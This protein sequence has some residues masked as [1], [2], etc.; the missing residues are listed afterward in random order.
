MSITIDHYVCLSNR[1]RDALVVDLANDF[2]PP[3]PEYVLRATGVVVRIFF[4]RR[5]D[6]V[7]EAY[8]PGAGISLHY[9]AKRTDQVVGATSPI[10]F[11]SAAFTRDAT[12]PDVVFWSATLDL[13]TTEFAA[14]FSSTT[15]IN[16]T[17]TIE[18]EEAG[19]ETPAAIFDA[20]GIHDVLRDTDTPPSAALPPY[21]LSPTDGTVLA[22]GLVSGVLSW[23]RLTTAQ[24]W[25]RFIANASLT[26]PFAR[27]TGVP[28]GRFEIATVIEL[29]EFRST[30]T[31]PLPGITQL[32]LGPDGTY[33]SGDGKSVWNDGGRW[34]IDAGNGEDF[35]STTLGHPSPVGLVYE[36]G[37]DHPDYQAPGQVVEGQV[38]AAV[39]LNGDT[40]PATT[41]R[42]GLV[43][44]AT[45]TET[46]TGTDTAR[47]VTPASLTSRTATETRRGIVELATPAEATAGTDTERA[48]TPAGGL[49]ALRGYV[50]PIAASRQPLL[51]WALSDP[52]T[53]LRRIWWNMGTTGNVTGSPLTMAGFLYQ[54][55]A[56]D[57]VNNA[58]LW[59]FSNTAASVGA[60]TGNQI[61]GLWH[62]NNGTLQL[63][64]GSGESNRAAWA[65]NGWRA[66]HAGKTVR[67]DVVSAADT[68]TL[69][70]V[71]QD[72]VLLT[73]W[74]LVVMAGTPP[75]WQ[76]P[77]SGGAW[78]IQGAGLP[79]AAFRPARPINRALTQAEVLQMIQLGG[80]LPRDR[81]GGC[82][83]P[84]ADPTLSSD[85]S[86][87]WQD[88]SNVYAVGGGQIVGT[89]VAQ[90]NAVYAQVA[91]GNRPMLA[92]QTV[93]YSIT[94]SA[95][96]GTFALQQGGN[97]NPAIAQ[98]SAPGTYSGT[99]TAVSSDSA[100]AAFGLKLMSVGPGSI[101]VTALTLVYEG[102]VFQDEVTR[103]AQV[104]DHGPNRTRGVMTNGVRPLCDRDAV[105]IRG[106]IAA[107]GNILGLGASDPLVYEPVLIKRIRIRP[108]ASASTTTTWRQNTS[109]GATIGTLTTSTLNQ[110][111][112]LPFT[113]GTAFDLNSGDKL[114]ITTT[115]ALDF[116]IDWSRR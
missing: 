102:A 48:L 39:V 43:E 52:A 74:T 16:L 45:D 64:I 26:F 5:V 81:A 98:F 56:V 60:D 88:A 28:T 108:T 103:T 106:S 38:V 59:Q 17:A 32:T 109:V 12:D 18:L 62:A 82:V 107:T 51:E 58:A 54:V 95:I 2:A 90:F 14:A 21:P 99:Y 111:V 31:T 85:S 25:A 15:P 44:L 40:A 50:D 63:R 23:V 76:S 113:A 110:W 19:T 33:T 24:L 79:A 20:L 53:S 34:I 13:N 97:I 22:G 86:A 30:G 83:S 84:L 61:T 42:L 115:A 105:P 29:D 104:L 57:P 72:G 27:V 80:L 71:Y 92:G 73:G 6:G 3:P 9:G 112:D 46:Q 75:N 1:V 4:C 114:H 41:S 37:P 91:G 93:R 116:E 67:L 87:I 47:A 94:V 11:Q 101:T 10:L 78:L 55:P 8:D 69:P 66:A 36:L 89:G 96:S 100:S 65:I 49:A 35:H 70:A 7:L 77:T 68:A